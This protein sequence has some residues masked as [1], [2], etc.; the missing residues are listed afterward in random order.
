M[1]EENPVSQ[2]APLL[3][4]VDATALH[5]VICALVGGPNEIRE[6]QITRNL[7]GYANPINT[8]IDNYNAWVKARAPKA[9]ETP[10]PSPDT[11]V[12]AEVPAVSPEPGGQPTA[13]PQG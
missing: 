11:E 9:P 8:L 5:E 6:L 1:S 12:A 7:A 2:E 3:I 10:P 4:E 13:D